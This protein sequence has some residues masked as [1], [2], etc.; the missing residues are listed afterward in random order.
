MEQDDV[1]WQSHVVTLIN[2]NQ[3]QAFGHTVEDCPQQFNQHSSH[4]VNIKCGM[5]IPLK[6]KGSNFLH[7]YA[8]TY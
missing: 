4:S 8:Q 3:M 7:P 6:M 2:T 1:L 5:D